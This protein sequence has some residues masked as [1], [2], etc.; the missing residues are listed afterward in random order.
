MA[1]P[2]KR[3]PAFRFY[4]VKCL[5]VNTKFF[6]VLNTAAPP[7]GLKKREIK[8]F[9]AKGGDLSYE[10]ASSFPVLAVK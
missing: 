1:G 3:G 7:P 8:V 9:A 4:N 5:R 10:T 2:T 6:Y